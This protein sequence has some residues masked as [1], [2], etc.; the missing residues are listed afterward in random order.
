MADGQTLSLR[1]QLQDSFDQLSAAEPPA[2]EAAA[3]E[4]AP[5]PAEAPAEP[6][7]EAGPARGPDGKFLPKDPASTEA[8]AQAAAP[9]VEPSPPAAPAAAEAPSEPIRIPPSLPAALKAK[10]ATLDPDVQQGFVAL[11]ESVQ[12]AKAEWGPKGQRLNRYDEII[13][14][15]VDRW[16]M[17]GLDEFSGVQSLIAA[18]SLLDRDPLGGIAQIARSYGLT[19]AHIAQ[20]FGLNGQTSAPQPGQEGQPAPTANPDFQAALQQAVAP[21]QQGFQTLQQQQQQFFQAQQ[22]A[23]IADAQRA[24]DAFA[25]DPA[26]MYF[27]DVQDAL[28]DIFARM[29]PDGRPH[30][31]RLKEAYDRAVWADPTIRPLL[32]DAQAN[33]RAAEEARKAA[34]A[35]AATEKAARDKA[36]AARRAG[37]S[38]TGSPAVGAGPPQGASRS[39]REDLQAAWQSQQGV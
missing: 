29:P 23:Q 7:P 37:G 28:A 12:K 3:T 26:N 24:I 17:N 36:E 22:A 30:G 18:Q 34:E 25:A 20:A 6:P 33:A 13:G 9:P 15:H 16:R 19:P 8:G 5:P 39:L 31:E 35:K 27:N 21:L 4:A 2:P 38:V 32:I 1:D 10:F 14:P 11:E